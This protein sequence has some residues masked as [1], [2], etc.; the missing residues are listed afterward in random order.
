MSV[1]PSAPSISTSAPP[2]LGWQLVKR[3]GSNTYDALVG[4]QIWMY[5]V[6]PNL[7]DPA[8]GP[9]YFRPFEIYERFIK[10]LLAR[11]RI[12]AQPRRYDHVFAVRQISN[13]PMFVGRPAIDAPSPPK[14]KGVLALKFE[15]DLGNRP[16]GSLSVYFPGT[17][18]SKVKPRLSITGAPHITPDV[19]I[20]GEFAKDYEL[21]PVRDDPVVTVRLLTGDDLGGYLDDY[22]NHLLPAEQLDSRSYDTLRHFLS[23]IGATS[24]Y[25][26]MNRV[27]T[28][29]T[30]QPGEEIDFSI[31]GRLEP[32][33]TAYFAIETITESGSVVSDVVELFAD[34]SGR[35]YEY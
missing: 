27:I 15:D 30:L 32:E 11:C 4:E 31:R 7:A 10:R 3:P 29:L 14:R 19:G 21:K 16:T 34:S 25:L 13:V 35:I 26:E 20:S 9:T 8:D 12:T 33:S 23:D 28:E 2:L 22:V 6:Y 1:M 18:A 24:T 17:A 5:G